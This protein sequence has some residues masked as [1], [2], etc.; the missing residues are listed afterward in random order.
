MRTQIKRKKTF[1]E[2]CQINRLMLN[3][4]FRRGT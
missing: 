2:Q 1:D 3:E 4:H